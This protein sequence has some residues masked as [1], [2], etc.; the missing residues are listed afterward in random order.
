MPRPRRPIHWWTE[1]GRVRS[2]TTSCSCTGFSA[3]SGNFWLPSSSLDRPSWP[4][5]ACSTEP[6]GHEICVCAL[7]ARE[8][9]VNP[10]FPRLDPWPPRIRSAEKGP[11]G[12]STRARKN[13]APRSTELVAAKS[14]KIAS[15]HNAHKNLVR[16][17]DR[18]HRAGPLST[19]TFPPTRPVRAHPDFSEFG[20]KMLLVV[21]FWPTRLRPRL[22]SLDRV[23]D[24]FRV[25]ALHAIDR[26]TLREKGLRETVG[27]KFTK[28]AG[29]SP[30]DGW[31]K[32]H[33]VGRWPPRATMPSR[34]GT[35][36]HVPKKLSPATPCG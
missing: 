26:A 24:E 12:C 22:A 14:C 8:L 34:V 1:A 9:L 15:V 21:K 30:R 25:C 29:G 36:F 2:W 35:N 28:L 32:I 33:K 16:P 13:I 23:G 3:E 7:R 6:D 11:C 20:Q 31:P 18:V 19:S 17:T 5:W 10:I 27:R 4:T